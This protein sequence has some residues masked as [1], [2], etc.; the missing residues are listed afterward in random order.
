MPVQLSSPFSC[1]LHVSK[2]P[3]QLSEEDLGF[4]PGLGAL[5]SLLKKRPPLAAVSRG[6]GFSLASVQSAHYFSSL[7]TLNTPNL[8]RLVPVVSAGNPKNYTIT[9][10]QAL[11]KSADLQFGSKLN[12]RHP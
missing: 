8:A 5:Q 2:P 11:S 3:A 6:H 9:P 1:G 7:L 4:R 10:S 12:A